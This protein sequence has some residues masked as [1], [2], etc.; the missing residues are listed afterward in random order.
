MRLIVDI[1]N[2]LD[3]LAFICQGRDQFCNQKYNVEID[4][5][6]DSHSFITKGMAEGTG[7]FLVI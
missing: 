5:V 2:G 4:W 7:D 6:Q 1:N 3:S